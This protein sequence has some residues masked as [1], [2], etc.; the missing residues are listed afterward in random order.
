MLPKLKWVHS[1]RVK[2]DSTLKV[3]VSQSKVYLQ[4]I[5][6]HEESF[7]KPWHPRTKGNMDIY[8]GQRMNIQKGEVG[9]SCVGSVGKHAS[10]CIA[11]YGNEA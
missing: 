11:G 9:F 5:G 8:F 4:Q 6:D 3:V 1:W 10:T 2:S 7:P